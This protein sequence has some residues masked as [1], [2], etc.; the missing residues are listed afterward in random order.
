TGVQTCAL[1]IW[2]SIA[3]ALSLARWTRRLAR[4][5][6]RGSRAR[7]TPRFAQDRGSPTRRTPRLTWDR[8]RSGEEPRGSL[9]RGIG[10]C[11]DEAG[12][13]ISPRR[14]APPARAAGRPSRPAPGP[15]RWLTR[16]NGR[17]P[18]PAG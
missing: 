6:D 16:A 17:S 4:E 5:K 14:R 18:R 2:R 7:K 12:P 3:R 9:A 8:A 15:G 1:P 11:T 10:W 13:A